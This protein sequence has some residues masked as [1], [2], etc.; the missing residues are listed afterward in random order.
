MEFFQYFNRLIE[1]RRR[2][3]RDDLATALTNG[4]I[5]DEAIPP[6]E[7]MSYFALLIVAGNETTRNAI[8]GGLAAL[9]EHRDQL[10][11]LR[12]EPELIPTAT[13]EITRWTSTVL[14]FTRTA[15]RDTILHGQPLRAGDLLVL[16]YPS[17]NRDEEVFAEPFKFDITRS[18]NPQIAFGIG[19]HYCLGA[20]LARLELQIMF[21]QLT[22][23]LQAV[24]LAGPI[25]RMRSSF[26][27]GIK[28]MPIH[29]QMRPRAG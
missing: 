6:F 7:M 15:T 18:P 16:F 8:T 9:I 22:E 25:Q 11:R 23:R 5:D 2:R 20:N 14:Q 13:D 26:V 27:G 29:F 4:R 17:A 1:D 19:E 10:E 28:H 3:P 12:R 21:R 24:E